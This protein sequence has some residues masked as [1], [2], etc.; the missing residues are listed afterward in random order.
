MTGTLEVCDG[1]ARLKANACGFRKK[2]YPQDTNLGESIF[3]DATGKS[4][5]ILIKN[6]YWIDLVENYSRYSWSFF[7]ETKSQLL[8]KMVEF[9][10][11]DVTRYSN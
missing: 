9:L 4:P 6:H 11:N 3:V 8:N 7:T 10:K 5:E 2:T 1:C